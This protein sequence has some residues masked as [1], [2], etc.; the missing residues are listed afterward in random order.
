[1]IHNEKYI[2]RCYT[3]SLVVFIL[4]ACKSG[5][6]SAGFS[7]AVLF[8][9]VT[10]IDGNG[11]APLEHTDIL[12]QGDTIVSIGKKL[13]AAGI[14]V[15][16]LAGKTMMPALIS[17]HVHV[18][19]LKGTTTKSVNYTRANILAQLKKYEDY[20]V[21]NIQVMGTDR[22]MLFK[23][24][25]RDSSI[26]G[27][28]PGARMYSA[29]YGFGVPEDGPPADFGMDRVYRPSHAGQIPSLMDSAAK[30]R[31]SVIKMWVDDFGGKSKKWT[32]QSI[33]LLSGKRIN[34]I[35]ASPHISIIWAMPGNLW[36]TES[37]L[38]LIA[39]VTAWLTIS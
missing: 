2:S 39:S 38:S 15:L 11:G 17:S 8:R 6:K 22:P 18:G 5:H 34:T 28:L 31:P 4:A 16:D 30:L 1:M 9:D 29:G 26:H 12:V 36:Q 20:G 3:L 23:S 13:D 33:G 19:T 7:E 27:L 25:L 32:L 37:I 14:K 24:G 21:E 35:S 10:L